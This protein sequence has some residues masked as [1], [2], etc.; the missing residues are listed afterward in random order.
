MVEYK[1]KDSG[2][3]DGMVKFIVHTKIKIS[4]MIYNVCVVL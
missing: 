3:L 2:I 4:W 1:I